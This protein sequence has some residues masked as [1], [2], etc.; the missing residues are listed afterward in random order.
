MF[1]KLTY[2]PHRPGEFAV[3]VARIVMIEPFYYLD[4]G[5]EYEGTKLHLDTG[6]EVECGEDLD[7]VL[8]TIEPSDTPSE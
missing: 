6:E 1:I 2:P 8:D 4:K 7:T 5:T 3:E